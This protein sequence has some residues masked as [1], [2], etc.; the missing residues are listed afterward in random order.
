MPSATRWS[1]AGAS[2]A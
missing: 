2:P 1:W